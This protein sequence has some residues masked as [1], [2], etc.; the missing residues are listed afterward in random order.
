MLTPKN[1]LADPREALRRFGQAVACD[2]WLVCDERSARALVDNLSR[3]AVLAARNGEG[4]ATSDRRLRLFSLFIRFY[5]RHVRMTALEDGEAAPPLSRG[6]DARDGGSP[7]ARAVRSLPLDL[8]E[9]LLLVV[10]ER[11]SHVEAAQALDI[12]LA[13]LIDRLGRARAMLSRALGEPSAV[14]PELSLGLAPRRAPYL[15][16]VK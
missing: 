9:A 1:E 15:R 12:S 8:R 11:F 4:S 16:L 3:R 7:M 13:A 5:R 10:L 14:A 6:A 2:N